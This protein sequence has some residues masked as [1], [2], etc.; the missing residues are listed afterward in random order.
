MCQILINSVNDF[1]FRT[2]LGLIG[3][4]YF[5]KIIFDIICA[6]NNWLYA[7]ELL[8]LDTLF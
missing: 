3:G 4:K 2:I 1:N 5:K 8:Y 7:N 6:I